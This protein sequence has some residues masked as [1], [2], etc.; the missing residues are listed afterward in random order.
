MYS[1]Q[2]SMFTLSRQW[3]FWK[4]ELSST[5][6]NKLCPGRDLGNNN[7]KRS[8]KEVPVRGAPKT[9]GPYQVSYAWRIYTTLFFI[10]STRAMALPVEV[11]I[12]LH[13][14]PSVPVPLY[15]RLTASHFSFATTYHLESVTRQFTPQ[16]DAFCLISSWFSC[17][18]VKSW[19][20]A[21]PP[22][23]S[24]ASWGEGRSSS[25]ILPCG[26]SF[27]SGSYK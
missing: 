11:R 3:Q 23:R 10:I 13:Y 19:Q 20:V 9:H 27:R 7:L 12:S 18:G 5:T 22:N 25:G 1:F 2:R 8:R 21:V 6:R 17:R 4:Q 15:V 24:R 14:W 26:W 16:K